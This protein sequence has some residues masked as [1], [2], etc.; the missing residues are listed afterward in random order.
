MR[1]EG[2]TILQIVITVIIMLIIMGVAIIYG[3]GVARESRMASI[4]NEIREIESALEEAHLLNEL[5]IGSEG[6]EIFGEVTVSEVEPSE[7]SNVLGGANTSRYYYLDFTSSRKLA[8]SLDLENV[9][10]DYILDY[11]NLNIYMVEGV[12]VVE[13]VAGSNETHTTIKFNS[14]EIVEYYNN[15]FVK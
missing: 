12:D 9:K 6:L 11:I 15:A 10:N 14:D 4:Y 1:N 13:N 8:T 2:V 3:Q 5:K 7:Y